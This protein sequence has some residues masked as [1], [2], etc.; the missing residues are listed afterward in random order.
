M[1]TDLK[2]VSGSCRKRGELGNQDPDSNPSAGNSPGFTNRSAICQG[3]F[4]RSALRRSRPRPRRASIP[5]TPPHRHKFSSSAGRVGSQNGSFRRITVGVSNECLLGDPVS[6]Q[7]LPPRSQMPS[8][9]RQPQ[10]L[11]LLIRIVALPGASI[12]GKFFA[13]TDHRRAS[14]PQLI[15]V[16]AMTPSMKMHLREERCG[17]RRNDSGD[18][19]SATQVSAPLASPMSSVLSRASSIRTTVDDVGDRACHFVG[20]G[21]KAT[22][23]VAVLSLHG[24]VARKKSKRWRRI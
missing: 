14:F 5:R 12:A 17:D 22:V 15:D 2:P 3:Q 18:G 1:T 21:V 8:S 24:V 10:L 11:L 6:H 9:T 13:A 20:G 19:A 23:T 7:P 4:A 16:C